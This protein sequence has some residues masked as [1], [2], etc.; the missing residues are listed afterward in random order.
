MDISWIRPEQLVEFEFI[1]LK[2]ENNFPE[3]LFNKWKETK[4]KNSDIAVLRKEAV[5]FL[6]ELENIKK[7]SQY[8]C[9]RFI[10][11]CGL[12]RPGAKSWPSSLL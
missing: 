12:N 10:L 5:P 6:N 8:F 1:Q 11:S 3:E 9:T 4:E 2:D 7:N